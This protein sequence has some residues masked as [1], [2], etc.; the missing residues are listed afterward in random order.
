MKA[1][2][3]NRQCWVMQQLGDISYVMVKRDF[4]P[5]NDYKKASRRKF[6]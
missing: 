5:L 4:H 3:H 1:A 6:S 2:L